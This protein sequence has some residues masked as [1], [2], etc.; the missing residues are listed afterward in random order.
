MTKKR[1]VGFSLDVLPS[2]RVRA[3]YLDSEGNRHSR[4]LDTKAEARAWC[5]SQLAALQAG[6]H[7]A[8]ASG[9][10]LFEDYA[11]ERMAAWRK[12]KPST[13][14]Q[15]ESQM[16]KH[17]FP[18]FGQTPVGKITAAH[19][20]AW[21]SEKE[22]EL[23]PSTLHVV[24]S[25][26]RR[27][28]ADA[29]KYNLVPR[30]PCVGIEL[31]EKHKREVRPL[32]LDQIDALHAAMPEN[33]ACAVLV[34]AWTGLRSGEVLGLR[35]HRLDLL[36]QRGADGARRTPSLYVAEQLQSLSGPPVLVPP[37]TKR[38]VRRVPMPRVLVDAL[39]AHLQRFPT[40]HEGFVFK[41]SNG[42]PVRRV[43]LNEVWNRAV[44]EA[45]LPAGTYF[46]DLRHTYASLLIEA[47]ESVKVVSDRL[48]H[49]SAVETLE[50]YAHLWPE[51]DERTVR[52]LD[53]A[54]AVH[55]GHVL[56]MQSP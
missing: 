28:M 49:A 19:I 15:V 33:L 7:V 35:R 51:S 10:V 26:F 2:G 50:T 47:G 23:A 25:W 11:K 37:K 17:L 4:T 32:S 3:R 13:R 14:Y 6:T 16:R 27:V 48:G 53:A 40:D 9:R 36:G 41:M 52:L 21:V 1:D 38:S 55:V 30:N 20:E 22:L 31:P 8:A 12:H 29:E 44:R 24:F 5:I 56:V 54:Y 43:R 45:G 34:A 42:E 46:H 39:A 18:I